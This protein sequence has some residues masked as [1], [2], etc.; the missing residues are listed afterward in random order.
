MFKLS[1]AFGP[2]LRSLTRP[3][4]STSIPRRAISASAP[5]NARYSTP[6]PEPE[7]AIGEPDEDMKI[8]EAMATEGNG[9]R[10]DIPTSYKEFLEKV[11]EKY[12]Y[13]KP[14]HYLGATVSPRRYL[15]RATTMF[16][17]PSSLFL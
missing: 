5:H 16:T 8:D 3:V 11:G 14:Q 4:A 2:C 1:S 13:A 17:Q 7:T 12:R 15:L 6:L 9:E 10:S